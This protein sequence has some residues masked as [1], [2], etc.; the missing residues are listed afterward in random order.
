MIDNSSRLRALKIPVLD[1]IARLP[2]T[3]KPTST[4]S[5]VHS[6]PPNNY[7]PPGPLNIYRPEQIIVPP[8]TISTPPQVYLPAK[9]PSNAYLPPSHQ[10]PSNTFLPPKETATK[11]PVQKPPSIAYIP[12]Q[13]TQKPPIA[14]Y[15]PPENISNIY[16]PPKPSTDHQNNANVGENAL[17]PPYHTNDCCCDDDENSS[18]AKLIVP[19]PLK[20]IAGLPQLYAKLILPL[21]SLDDESMRKLSKL[22]LETDKIDVAELIGI[23]LET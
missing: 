5:Y 10:K 20:A 17:L 6:T 13:I 19:V 8:A 12:Q 11:K 14:A 15:L 3:L 2:V 23:I 16:L 9:Q 21:K 4:D 18:S 7:I 22:N 1:Q